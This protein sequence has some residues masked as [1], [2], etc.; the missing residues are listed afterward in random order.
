[1]RIPIRVQ[2][3][4]LLLISSL[5]GLAVISIAVWVT[6]HDFVLQVRASRLTLTASL[7]AAQLTSNLNLMQTSASFVSS[8]VLVQRALARY[9]QNGNNTAANWASAQA[10]MQAAIGGVGSLGQALLLQSMVFPKNAD[11]PAGRASL[12]N[13]T[14][15]GGP[16]TITLPYTY[17]NGT[18]ILLGANDTDAGPWGYPPPLYPN[19]TYVSQTYNSTWNISE[20][21]YDGDLLTPGSTLLLGPWAVN[22]T[23]SLMS[24]TIPIINNT[25]DLDVLGFITVV[26]DASLITDILAS[27]EGLDSTGETLIVGPGTRTNV[28]PRDNTTHGTDTRTEDPGVLLHYVIPLNASDASRH[29]NQVLGSA[30][31]PFNISQFSTIRSAVAAL[32]DPS[33]PQSGANLY[34]TNE[35]GEQV[36]VGWAVPQIALVD[37]FV[38]VELTRAEVWAPINRLRDILLACLFATAGFMAVIAFPLA[39][40]ASLPILRLRQATLN[41]VAPPGTESRAGSSVGSFGSDIDAGETG[42]V[43][44]RAEDPPE[45]EEAALARKEGFFVGA[46]TRWLR[47]NPEADAQAQRAERRKKAFNIPQKVK[48]RPK[49]VHDELS[50]LTATF[51]AM[52]DELMMQYSRLEERVQERT[53]ELELSKK[54]AEAANESKTLFI[55]NISH[56]LKTPLN[57]ILGMCAVCMQEDDPL[58]LKRSLG[59]I[60]KSGDLLLN[61]LTDLLTFSKNQVG[62]HLT[63]DEKEFRLRDV[64]SQTLAIFD[65]QA[66]DGQIDLRVVYEGGPAPEGV[67][68]QGASLPAEYGPPGTGRIRDMILWGDLH[69]ILQ[70]VINL[71]SNSLKFTE[72]GGK[73]TLI[74]RCL[75]DLPPPTTTD[76]P[77]S[78]ASSRTSRQGGRR[79]SSR[80][81]HSKAGSDATLANSAKV[82]AAAPGPAD[83]H[84]GASPPPPPAGRL[85]WFEF[86]VIDTGPGI[87]ESLQKQIFEPFVQ[88]DLRLSKK[89]GG[90]GLGLSICQQLATLMRGGIRVSSTV[91]EGATFTMRI[92]LRHLQSRADSSASS[93]HEFTL[94]DAA[95]GN[96]NTGMMGSRRGSESEEAFGAERNAS[97]VGG[98]Q[99]QQQHHE[100]QHHNTSNG[101]AGGGDRSSTGRMGSIADGLSAHDAQQPRLV[102]LSSPFFAASQP[103]ESPGSQPGA[104]E[105]LAASAAG[106]PRLRVLV[107]EDNQVNQEVVLRMLKLE[108]IY[109]V[110]VARDGQEALERVQESMSDSHPGAKPFNLIFMDVQMPN[111]DGLQSTRL[112][113]AAGYQQPIVALTAFDQESNIRD[114]LASGMNYFL[115][116]PIR[117][118]QLKKVLKEYCAPIPEAENEDAASPQ[119]SPEAAVKEDPLQLAGPLEPPP[120]VVVMPQQPQP[121]QQQQHDSHPSPKTV[122]TTTTGVHDPPDASSGLGFL[123]DLT[124][125]L[126]P[127]FP[128]AQFSSPSESS[129]GLLSRDASFGPPS[130]GADDGEEED[131]RPLAPRRGVEE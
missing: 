8:R 75:P 46:V 33:T 127:P 79:T 35:N 44:L 129:S 29:P 58:R 47:R 119:P 128:S 14:A 100:E 110:T 97:V 22:E 104:M 113:R 56:E 121:Q 6:V 131:R 72:P 59:I 111:V 108:D 82:P 102:G 51:N 41:S 101:S 49:L 64:S 7:K 71:V 25:S 30:Q 4:S 61:L 122:P 86:E 117:R 63:L 98:H 107:A 3:G 94:L 2:L 1:M 124:P 84:R 125:S 89:Y 13:T 23:L 16:D 60:Y 26:M 36:S 66:R 96:G 32:N 85:L 21:S 83:S 80:L 40:F 109:D 54:A 69:R 55:A 95:S 74:L 103:M 28:F 10:D 90:T 38:L 57:G 19:L 105:R 120:T 48:E 12:M 88:G 24:L 115:S 65:K 91:G 78:R 31:P 15:M 126:T 17:P 52:S 50:E 37:W 62:Q 123:P 11:G 77:G 87:A 81:Q 34:A 73:V 114:C 9:A 67:S 70:V 27:P 106:T 18:H 112:I 99:Q 42:S 92:P 68:S 76:A 39:H 5:V 118:P 20:A 93:A 53:R 43:I 116:K 45:P 130:S